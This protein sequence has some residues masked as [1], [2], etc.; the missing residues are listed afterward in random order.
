MIKCILTTLLLLSSSLTQAHTPT[1]NG[2]KDS[3]QSTISECIAATTSK[4]DLLECMKNRNA[5]MDTE[6]DHTVVKCLLNSDDKRIYWY[7]D[8]IRG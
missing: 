5:D 3:A 2:G 1:A 6:E 4:T 8:C 7:E